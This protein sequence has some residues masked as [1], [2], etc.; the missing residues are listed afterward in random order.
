MKILEQID[1]KDECQKMPL[2][3][4]DD[5]AISTTSLNQMVLHQT[6][7][8]SLTEVEL[9]TRI[10]GKKNKKSRLQMLSA[11]STRFD[12]A[13]LLQIYQ[14]DQDHAENHRE[15]NVL[16][17]SHGDF[18]IISQKLGQAQS[19]SPEAAENSLQQGALLAPN[20]VIDPFILERANTI[21]SQ[22]CKQK[23][24]KK[25]NQLRGLSDHLDRILDNELSQIK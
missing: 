17:I 6:L 9:L 19:S 5:F 23:T 21:I 4:I 22:I 8:Q 24:N 20:N 14:P 15:P 13:N 11:I 10:T 1:Q 25:I 7:Y 16:S 18:S 3:L 2:I 12:S